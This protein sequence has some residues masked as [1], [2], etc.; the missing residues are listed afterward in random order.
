[1]PSH[2]LVSISARDFVFSGTALDPLTTSGCQHIQPFTVSA[3]MHPR[4]SSLR[5]VDFSFFFMKKPL[6]RAQKKVP[7]EK[8]QWKK[9]T[10]PGSIVLTL[11]SKHHFAPRTE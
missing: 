2:G 3:E 10:L 9:A 6:A 5:A 7:A 11:E 1:M 4:G 8:K